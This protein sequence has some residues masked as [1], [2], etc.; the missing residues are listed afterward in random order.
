MNQD[1]WLAWKLQTS[2]KWA[3]VEDAMKVVNIDFIDSDHQTLIELALKLN[4]VIDKSQTEFS[5][6]LIR[7]TEQLLMDFYTYA[8]LHFDR[9][10]VFMS[11]NCLSDIESHK[12]EHNQILVMLQEHIEAFKAGKII[13]DMKIKY[14]I[15]DWLIHHINVVDF[16]FFAADKW[17]DYLMKATEWDQI[18][19]IISITGIPTI[20]SQHQDLIIEALCLVEVLKKGTLSNKPDELI[21]QYKRHILEHFEFEEEFMRRNRMIQTDEHLMN[22]AHFVERIKEIPGEIFSGQMSPDELKSWLLLWWIDH[23]N[24][25]DSVTFDYNNWANRLVE[26]SNQLSEVEEILRRTNIA[27]IDQQHLE[28]MQEVFEFNQLV[29]R[30]PASL[31]TIESGDREMFEKRLKKIL[32]LVNQHFSHEE[33]IMEKW[34][35]DEL[36]KHRLEHERIR[37][38]LEDIMRYYKSGYLIVSDSI[39]TIILDWWL[40]HTNT[41][42][43]KTFV[44]R[45]PKGGD[46]IERIQ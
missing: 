34:I 24:G 22:H 41:V 45:A 8:K 31:D 36:V 2:K 4:R 39:K 5:M 16:N 32:T 23:I 25:V 3:D 46:Q 27:S 14:Q 6:A 9:E 40:R 7:E 1:K 29:N 38:S 30:M 33:H 44:R 10:E 15:M 21:Q 35:P 37:M 12:N 11:Q 19:E 20:D 28:V 17:R 42:D 43:Y 26:Q 13:L 18:K